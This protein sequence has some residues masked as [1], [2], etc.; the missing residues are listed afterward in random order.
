MRY[1]LALV[2]EVTLAALMNYTST[3][4]SKPS[5][6]YSVNA[7]ATQLLRPVVRRRLRPTNG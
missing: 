2:L 5:P 4:Q 6:G 3:T 7:D 1:V